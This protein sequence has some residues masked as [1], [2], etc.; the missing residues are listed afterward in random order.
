MLSVSTWSPTQGLDRRRAR[1]RANQRPRTE[2]T[3]PAE[4]V[5]RAV[6]RR[7]VGD[8]DRLGNIVQRNI[9]DECRHGLVG[10]GGVASVAELVNPPI[11]PRLRVSTQVLARLP[12]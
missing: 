4:V 5:D 2:A 3:D 9:L 10:W 1:E 6:H 11:L 12:A 7:F 8:R